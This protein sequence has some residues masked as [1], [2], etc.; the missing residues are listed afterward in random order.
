MRVTDEFR[1]RDDQ[2]VEYRVIRWQREIDTPRLQGRS[3]RLGLPEYRLADGSAL[4]F[5]AE[6]TFEV[7]VTGKRI[8]RIR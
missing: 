4:N 8:R 1:A 6:D 2:G 3:S 7:V 5:I